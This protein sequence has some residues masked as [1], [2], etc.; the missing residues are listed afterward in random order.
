MDQYNKGKLG[1]CGTCGA[2]INNAETITCNTCVAEK[3]EYV[4]E[5]ITEVL[6]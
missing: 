4:Y 1:F 3:N 5:A 6:A 2:P